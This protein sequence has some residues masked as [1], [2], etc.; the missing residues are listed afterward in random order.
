MRREVQFGEHGQAKR[1]SE[2]IRPE[3]SAS[4]VNCE[5]LLFRTLLGLIRTFVGA[6]FL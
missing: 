3:V 2:R 4:I 1:D 5:G 6:V